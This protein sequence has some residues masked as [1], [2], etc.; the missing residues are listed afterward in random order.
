MSTGFLCSDDLR[1]LTGWKLKSRQIAWLREAGI[2]F[3]VNATGHPV[4]TW[5]AVEG[6]QATAAAPQPAAQGWT[7]R[8]IAGGA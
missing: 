2:P 6:R 3:R 4:V 1:L 7:P 5:A 8:V